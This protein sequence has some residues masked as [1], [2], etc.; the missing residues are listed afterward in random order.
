MSG[1]FVANT[2]PR[3]PKTKLRL[4]TFKKYYLK[5]CSEVCARLSLF[6]TQKGSRAHIILGTERPKREASLTIFYCGS[7]KQENLCLF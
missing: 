2:R 5:F 3:A 4:C 7:S 6:D 1:T